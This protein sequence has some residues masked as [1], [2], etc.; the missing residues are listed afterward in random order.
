MRATLH[1]M[2]DRYADA[3]RARRAELRGERALLE[4]GHRADLRSELALG[5]IAASDAASTALAELGRQARGHAAAADRAALVALPAQI[6]AALDAVALA[7]NARLT[8][9]LGPA[10]RRI[11]TSRALWLGTGWPRLPGPRLPVVAV[12][13]PEPL[14][15]RSL[16]AGAAEGLA[17]WRFALLPLAALPLL[18]LP[19]L[20]GLALAPLAVGIGAT[21]VVVAIRSRRLALQRAALR[22]SA[23]ETLAAAGAALDA[24]V[25]RRLLELERAAAAELDTAVVRRRALVDAELRALAPEAARG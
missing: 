22:R 10:L 12:P 2:A 21:A 4:G 23:D 18:G 6:A 3:V 17:L 1:G 8:A 14:P 11:A 20:G 5:R 13:E 16:L 15:A 9:E 25:G 19:A 24:D 7:V